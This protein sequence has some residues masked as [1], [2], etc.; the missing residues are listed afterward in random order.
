[1]EAVL[2]LAEGLPGLEDVR[3]VGEHDNSDLTETEQRQREQTEGV[4]GAALAAGDAAVWVVAQGLE[5]AAKGR[6]WRSTHDSL[7]AY[8][9][10]RIGRSAVYGRQ[11]RKNAPLALETAKRTGSVPKPS[12]VKVTRKTEQHHGRDAAVT[13]YE[14][15]RD[16]STELGN[17]PTAERL[18]AVHN[19]LPEHLPDQIDAQRAV[20]EQAARHTLSTQQ[21]KPDPVGVSP[22]PEPPAPRMAGHWPIRL[23][24]LDTLRRSAG[25]FEH[26]S[27]VGASIEAPTADGAVSER[28]GTDDGEDTGTVSEYLITL[29]EALRALNAVNRSITRDTFTQAATDP[30]HA[31]EYERVRRAIIEKASTIREKA[32][33]APTG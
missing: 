9:E 25:S 20:I 24:D 14:V 10:A 3:A 18:M 26:E 30:S 23:P 15:V 1:M 29:E 33:H 31:A 12:Q 17:R 22:A 7:G 4:I 5:R 27:S 21:A 11:L 28:A 6:W 16:V 13:L 19:S 2:R 8:V 32:L